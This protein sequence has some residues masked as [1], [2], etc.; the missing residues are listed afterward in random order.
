MTEQGD[1]VPKQEQEDG[2]RASGQYQSKGTRSEQG[3]NDRATGMPMSQQGDND[4]ACGQC[5]SNRDADVAAT[6]G[7]CHSKGI[8]IEQGDSA[9]ASGLS[10][11]KETMT[12]QGKRTVTEQRDFDRAG[13][14]VAGSLSSHRFSLQGP[15]TLSR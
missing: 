15:S 4:R 10:H 13:G 12:K 14:T 8:V 7:R 3:D 1:D 5:Q 11:S 9:E 6:G 2:I